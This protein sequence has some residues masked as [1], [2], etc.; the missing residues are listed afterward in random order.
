[1]AKI[2]LLEVNSLELFKPRYFKEA[3]S[4]PDS[5]K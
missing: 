4:D 5:N 3:I 2:S 1:M